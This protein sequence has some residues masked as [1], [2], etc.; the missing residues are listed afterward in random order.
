MTDSE[1]GSMLVGQRAS[2][3]LGGPEMYRVASRALMAGCEEGKSSVKSRVVREGG[4]AAWAVA[5]SVER[6]ETMGHSW[7][8]ES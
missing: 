5:L 8:L 7:G 2:R 4:C 3:K 1:A 6:W